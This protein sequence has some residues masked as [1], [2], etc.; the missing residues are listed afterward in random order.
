MKKMEIIARA[1]ATKIQYSVQEAIY[2]VMSELWLRK[3]FPR[4]IFL[5]SN[6]P[7]KH[8]KIFKKK[9]DI[10]ELPDDS[11]DLFQLNMLDRYLDQPARDFENEKCNILD[12]LCFAEFFSLY[13]TDPKS[14]DCSSNN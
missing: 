10:D 7:K 5:N 4:V 11:I 6:L 13:Y 12:H 2:L 3:M 8:Y 9:A 14:E 1:Y